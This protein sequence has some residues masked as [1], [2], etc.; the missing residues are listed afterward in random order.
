M[1]QENRGKEYY[2]EKSRERK[3]ATLRKRAEAAVSRNEHMPIDKFTKEHLDKVEA[4]YQQLKE[5][6]GK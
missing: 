4:L 1:E 5:R 2:I 6:K 3:D